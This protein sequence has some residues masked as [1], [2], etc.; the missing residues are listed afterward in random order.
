[1]DGLKIKPPRLSSGPPPPKEFGAIKLASTPESRLRIVRNC[2][3]GGAH[4]LGP[5]P[6]LSLLGTGLRAL[7]SLF[8]R[9]P[10]W[11]LCFVDL[12]CFQEVGRAGTQARSRRVCMTAYCIRPSNVFVCHLQEIQSRWRG[13]QPT[14]RYHESIVDG[15]MK[16]KMSSNG[17]TAPSRALQPS[18]HASWLIF[19]D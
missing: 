4:T 14:T 8:M 13:K 2:L 7:F 6:R 5:A 10:E 12:L 19:S 11:V 16:G 1:M 15:T 18:P 3:D 9:W 17:P